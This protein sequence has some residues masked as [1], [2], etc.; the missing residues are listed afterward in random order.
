MFCSFYA[1]LARFWTFTSFSQPDNGGQDCSKNVLSRAPR[2]CTVTTMR[3]AVP[4]WER[5]TT[6]QHTQVYYHFSSKTWSDSTSHLKAALREKALLASSLV[7]SV[8]PSQ[9]SVLAQAMSVLLNPPGSKSLFVH[10]I[11]TSTV[12][13]IKLM[14]SKWGRCVKL[15]HGW[16]KRLC[17]ALCTGLVGQETCWCGQGCTCFAV[18]WENYS[19]SIWLCFLMILLWSCSRRWVMKRGLDSTVSYLTGLPC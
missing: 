14:A 2:S 15:P 8:P 17:Q 11:L 13:K 5:H 9:P 3:S 18:P 10:T 6:W 7:T 12:S 16:Q 1:L 4:A 19:T